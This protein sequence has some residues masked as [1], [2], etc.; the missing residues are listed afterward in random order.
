MHITVYGRPI[1]QGSKIRT[2]WSMRDANGD[3]LAPWRDNVRSAAIDALRIGPEDSQ[4]MAER[5]G[6]PFG[7]DAVIVDITFTFARPATHFGTGR[8]ADTVKVSAPRHPSTHAIGDIDKLA[9]A[10]LDALTDAGMWK[11]D[12]QVVTLV[13][14][15]LFVGQDIALDRPGAVISIQA[16]S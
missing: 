4:G 16:A 9:R 14:R 15:K 7:T 12:S 3:T 13:A 6:N 8:N 1:T 5:I 11:D 10:C 2:K